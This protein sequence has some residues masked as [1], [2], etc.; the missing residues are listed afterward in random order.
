MPT[1]IGKR[2]WSRGG[3]DEPGC[4]SNNLTYKIEVICDSHDSNV[5][6]RSGKEKPLITFAGARP[7]QWG[8]VVWMG[9]DNLPTAAV[10][11]HVVVRRGV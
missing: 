2:N 7:S 3:A 10:G 6:R 9:D 8:V 5:S 11:Y 4:W 1:H